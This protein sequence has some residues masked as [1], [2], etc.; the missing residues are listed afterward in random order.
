MFNEKELIKRFITSIVLIILLSLMLKSSV[1]L[2]SSLL[3]IFVFSWIEFSF[4][5]EKIFK[6][7]KNFFYFKYIFKF[8]IFIYLLF[9]INIIVDEF[10][11][12]QPNISQNILFVI[13]VCIFSDIGG[14]VFGKIFKGKKLTKISPNKTFA[15]MYGSFILTIIFTIIYCHYLNIDNLKIYIIN[16]LLISLV[17]QLGDLF[18]SYLKKSNVKDTGN[19]L[20]GHGGI[21]DRIDGILFALP[22]GIVLM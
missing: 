2:I 8:V 10:L 4:L 3:L 11:L 9:F 15:R 20:P 19:I 22:F 5:F 7:K 14:F 6:K 13:T 1:V 21:L 16:C 18:V 12:N 17:C